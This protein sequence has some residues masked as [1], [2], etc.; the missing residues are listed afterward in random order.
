MDLRVRFGTPLLW[1]GNGEGRLD[2][3]IDRL[4]LSLL[5]SP[6]LPLPLLVFFSTDTSFSG[7]D[8][9]PDVFLVTRVLD[10]TATCLL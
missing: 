8:S 9:S 2:V 1:L 5:L 3:S 10:T 6:W 7:S 4:S